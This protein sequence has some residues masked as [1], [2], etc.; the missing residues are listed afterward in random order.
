MRFPVPA[1]LPMPTEKLEEFDYATLRT[2]AMASLFEAF[3]SLCE[4]TVMV[5]RNARV[6]W[7]NERYAARFGIADARQAIGKKIEEIIPTS[8]MRE[9]VR[10]GR[11]LLLDI[12]DVNGE[13]FV[14]TRIPIKDDAGETMGA[15]GFALYDKLQP[16][17]PFYARLHKL[18]HQLAQTQQHL[19][20]ERRSKYTFTHYIGNSPAATSALRS[21]EVAAMTRTSIFTTLL[22]PS[23][24]TSFSCSTRSS[25]AC[26]VSGMSP[27][28]S[29]KRVP[30]LASSN[31]PTRALRSA[32]V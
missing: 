11:P 15:I 14:V 32:P 6:V 23:G 19:A 18:Q 5:D 17:Q 8:L 9:V 26:S 3:D 10:T 24:S 7:I 22:A 21:R 16:L 25:L 28:S 31:F 13:S 20:A 27:I 29:R 4:G 1:P 30:P 2:R 12:L